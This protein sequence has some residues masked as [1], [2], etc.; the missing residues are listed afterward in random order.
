MTDDWFNYS[1]P[2]SPTTPDYWLDHH[3]KTYEQYKR[4]RWIQ[5]NIP[6]LGPLYESYMQGKSNEEYI[7]QTMENSNIDWND[8]VN[9]YHS[10]LLNGNNTA[11]N[12]VSA[13]ATVSSNIK[14]LYR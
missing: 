14:R 9:P 5:K 2:Y 3:P 6:I 13:A 10:S 7:D 12:Y 8:I 1:D 4:Q 11:V